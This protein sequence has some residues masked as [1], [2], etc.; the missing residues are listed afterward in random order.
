MELTVFGVPS[1]DGEWGKLVW[2][3]CFASEALP[4]HLPS[5]LGSCQPGTPFMFIYL[6]ACSSLSWGGPCL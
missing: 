6:L 3:V 4:L 1:P 2:M 5:V